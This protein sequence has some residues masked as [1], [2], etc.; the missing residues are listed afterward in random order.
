MTDKPKTNKPPKRHIKMYASDALIER[1]KE[2]ADEKG[3]SNSTYLLMAVDE[4][5]RKNNAN[6]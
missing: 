4:Y 6:K 3:V 5:R 1:V 2:L